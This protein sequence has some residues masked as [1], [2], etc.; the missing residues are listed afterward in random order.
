MQLAIPAFIAGVLIFF[1]PCTL[2]VLPAYLGFLTGATAP[3]TEKTGRSSNR[4]KAVTNSLLFSLGFS[5]VFIAFGVAFGAGGAL[6]AGHRQLLARLAGLFVI[7]FGLFM[8]R[9]TGWRLFAFLNR[10]TRPRFSFLRPGKPLSAA[11]FGASFA[12]GWSPCIGP[13]LGSVLVLAARDATAV[14]GGV[15]LAIF[16]LGFSVPFLLTA[17]GAEKMLRFLSRFKGKVQAIERVGGALL[18]AMGTLMLL[19]KTSLWS[20]FIYQHLQLVK[21]ERLL[22]YL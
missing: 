6:L 1:A 2:P 11:L 4:K 14:Q 12:L 10:D 21:Y 13:I 8:L 19:D 17:L 16:S 7:A 3:E 18:I 15:L 9:P 20:G 22:D 5:V